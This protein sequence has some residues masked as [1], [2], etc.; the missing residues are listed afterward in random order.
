MKNA[1]KKIED[2]N[3]WVVATKED[4]EEARKK[5]LYKGLISMAAKEE[6]RLSPTHIGALVFLVADSIEQQMFNWYESGGEKVFDEDDQRLAQVESLLYLLEDLFPYH[7]AK[8]S[9]SEK[10]YTTI[11]DGILFR[12]LGLIRKL[13]S[14]PP[15]VEKFYLD[16]EVIDAE[17]Y[18]KSSVCSICGGKQANYHCTNVV[19]HEDCLAKQRWY[20]C[21]WCGWLYP[22]NKKRCERKGKCKE[23]ELVKCKPN[24]F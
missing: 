20:R 6:F 8:N 16:Y 5:G 10:K 24:D 12:K 2:K 21:E 7:F 23:K 11:G 18:R 15:Q 17:Y 19:V 3:R 13:V 14:F 4:M 22:N 9:S 1:R